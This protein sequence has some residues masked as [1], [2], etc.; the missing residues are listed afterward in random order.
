MQHFILDGERRVV[1]ADV[2]AWGRW[3]GTAGSLEIARTEARHLLV[4][5][6]FAGVD[7][8]FGE[9]PP[10]FFETRVLDGID[11][12]ECRETSSWAEA[13]VEHEAM[14]ERWSGWADAARSAMERALADR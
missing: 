4:L 14:T 5:T 7:I 1:Q 8:S 9:G 6:S 13:L 12:L 2:L 11:E 10:M 3:V